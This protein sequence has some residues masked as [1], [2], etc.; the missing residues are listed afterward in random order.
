MRSICQLRGEH[1]A[2]RRQSKTATRAGQSETAIR[3]SLL[4]KHNF[5]TAEDI[6]D[7]CDF[8]V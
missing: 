8:H 5:I 3:T 6:L 1:P 7:S 4:L 2:R